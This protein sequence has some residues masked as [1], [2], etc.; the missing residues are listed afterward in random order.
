MGEGVR[1]VPAGE[2]T[3]AGSSAERYVVVGSGKTALDTCVW[4]LTHGV[5]ASAVQWIRP[6]EAWW[7]NRRF[8]QP[9][10]GLPQF[11]KAIGLQLKI[12]AQ[13]TSVEDVF[14]RLEANNFFLRVDPAVTPTMSRGAML[15]EA[16]LELLQQITDVVRLGHVRRIDRERI[17]LDDGSVPT[18]PGTLHVHCAAIGL[19]RPPL[20]AIFQ[21]DRVTI[22]PLFWSFACYPAALLG[23]IEAT[24][25]DDAEKNRVCPP[26][27]YWDEPRDYLSAY[28]A[29]MVHDRACAAH[30]AVV[31]WSRATRLNAMSGLS[32]HAGHPG[33]AQTFVDIKQYSAAAAANLAKLLH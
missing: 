13:A 5:P 22:Q 3:R 19:A 16:E 31:A 28:L 12:M 29:R 7:L 1:C 18:T 23:V 32:A 8:H 17:T 15:S 25:D 6:R 20:R 30:P 27:K 14:E 24:I 11:F 26:I 21:A 10:E 9:G 33:V 2:V 4:L